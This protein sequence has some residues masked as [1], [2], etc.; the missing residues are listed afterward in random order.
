MKSSVLSLRLCAFVYCDHKAMLVKNWWIE[1][2]RVASLKT[3]ISVSV[4]SLIKT[5]SCCRDHVQGLNY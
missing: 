3:D 1:Y 4:A 2:G 5:C